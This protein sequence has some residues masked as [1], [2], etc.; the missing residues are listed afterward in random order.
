MVRQILTQADPKCLLR[1]KANHPINDDFFL[2]IYR[3][4][5]ISN[6]RVE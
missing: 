1:G 6:I 5:L 2:N 3:Q 4:K